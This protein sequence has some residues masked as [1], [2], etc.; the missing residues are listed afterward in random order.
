[1]RIGYRIADWLEFRWVTPAFAGW[2]LAFLALFFFAAA[3]NTMAGWLY[4]LS[5]VTIAL[6]GISAILPPRSL[7]TLKVTRL[8]IQPVTVGDQITVEI[9]IEN[10][11]TQLKTL[12]QVQDVLPFVLGKPVHKSIEMIP[13]QSIYKWTYYHLTKRRGVYR[14][15]DVQLRTGAPLGLFWCRRNRIAKASAIVYPTVLPLQKCPLV[16]Q[17]GQDETYMLSDRA[18]SQMATQG[19]TRT[20]RPYRHGDPMRLIHWRSS[21]RF[22]ELRVRE[23]EI[24]TGGQEVIIALDSG[25]KWERDRFEEAVIVAASLYFYASKRQLSVRLWTAATGLI[26]GNLVVLEALAGVNVGEEGVK[27]IPHIPLIWLTQNP[28]SLSQLPLGS[29]WLLWPPSTG[30]EGEKTIAKRDFPGIEIRPDQPL[31]AQLQTPLSF[32]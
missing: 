12:L 32:L 3:S 22:G 13:P 31:E 2:L 8:P 29:R 10:K 14:W 1:M 5:G 28:L 9:E 6:L 11:S 26:V 23:L 27:N 24:S 25:G 4:V 7:S 16:D 17:L 19:V 30:E 15:E 21:A 20:L 18:Q